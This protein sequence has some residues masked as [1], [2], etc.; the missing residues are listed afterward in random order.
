MYVDCTNSYTDFSANKWIELPGMPST[1]SFEGCG[2]VR[3]PVT[4]HAESVVV[5]GGN[6]SRKTADIFDLTTRTWSNG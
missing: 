4:G 6:P 3:N 5:A 1:R 2:V